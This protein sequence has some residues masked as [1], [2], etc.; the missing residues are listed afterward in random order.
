M[1]IRRSR[2]GVPID[3]ALVERVRAIVDDPA[4]YHEAMWRIEE[5]R[6]TIATADI[7]LA[8]ASTLGA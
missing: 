5:A 6:L 8:V 2:T 1:W 7:A 4:R 3:A